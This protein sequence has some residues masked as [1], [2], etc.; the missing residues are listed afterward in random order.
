M[1]AKK[2]TSAIPL[3]VPAASA[4]D[5]ADRPYSH[6]FNSPET[7]TLLRVNAYGNKITRP[8]A[9]KPDV[10]GVLVDTV[11]YL[12]QSGE[13]TDFD[14]IVMMFLITKFSKANN[15]GEPPRERSIKFSIAEFMAMRNVADTTENRKKIK[16]KI[17]ET[18][19]RLSATVISFTSKATSPFNRKREDVEIRSVLT[20]GMIS[21]RGGFIISLG[22]GFANY[23][24][25]AAT[26]PIHHSLFTVDA[27][28]NRSFQI[29]FQLAVYYRIKSAERKGDI[30][31]EYANK[32]RFGNL[33]RCAGFP[34]FD[35]IK[36]QNRNF[37]KR[38]VDP[39]ISALNHLVDKGYLT[40]YALCK[41]DGTVITT[42]ERTRIPS[43]DY[44]D[45]YISFQLATPPVNGVIARVLDPMPDKLTQ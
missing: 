11:S 8:N 26:V 21:Y 16:K 40:E 6:V 31:H 3:S 14:Q 12:C 30:N 7:N 27:R 22:S 43:S 10:V 36:Q 15:L 32:I 37:K 4:P 25:H 33:A 42:E 39:I 17:T 45:L 29:G 2:T 5:S 38:I 34:S 35:E 18:F 19:E 44:E 24:C 9:L 28:V 20:E 13:L 41:K 1:T 23:L